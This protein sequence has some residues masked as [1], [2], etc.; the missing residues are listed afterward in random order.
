M[1]FV[2]EQNTC[3]GEQ[4]QFPAEMAAAMN[5]TSLGDAV[6]VLRVEGRGFIQQWRRRRTKHVRGRGVKQPRV[7]RRLRDG[8][9]EM[10]QTANMHRMAALKE[11][12]IARR[13]AG[14][15]RG[16]VKRGQIITFGGLH[17][18]YQSPNRL[19]L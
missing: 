11:G 12:R 13:Q 2:V 6:N 4:S 8:M 5:A 7:A 9:E 17:F 19:R 15:L 18:F 1:R 10:K 3:G 16:M 14:V